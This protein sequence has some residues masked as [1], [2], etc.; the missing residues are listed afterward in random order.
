MSKRIPPRHYNIYGNGAPL[1]AKAVPNPNH[2]PFR[3]D[4]HVPGRLE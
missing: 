4:F 3:I 2:T 1:K